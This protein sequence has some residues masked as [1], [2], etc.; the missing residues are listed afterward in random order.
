MLWRGCITEAQAA[1]QAEGGEKADAAVREGGDSA[2]GVYFSTQDGQLKL[3]IL[4]GGGRKRLAQPI[5]CPHGG[6][7]GGWLALKMDG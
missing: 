7:M 4:S 3:S 5:A 1:G 6:K 2:G